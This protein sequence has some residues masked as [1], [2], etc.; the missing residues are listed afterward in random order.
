MNNDEEQPFLFNRPELRKI[1][2]RNK[3]RANYRS[4]TDEVNRVTEPKYSA[5]DRLCIWLF[6]TIHSDFISIDR[7]TFIQI[8]LSIEGLKRIIFILQ[9][10]ADKSMTPEKLDE[11]VKK[12]FR[13]TD[14]EIR[15]NPAERP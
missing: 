4:M 7:Q 11:Y 3:F 6:K 1:K 9:P 5:Y 12:N 8:L 13:D 14:D 2:A 15:R 10:M